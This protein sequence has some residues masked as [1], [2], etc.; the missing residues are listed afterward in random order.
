MNNSS[1]LPDIKHQA[2]RRMMSQIRRDEG[3]YSKLLA[4]HNNNRLVQAQNT[5]N[6]ALRKF[7]ASNPN[8]NERNQMVSNYYN[9]KRN[10]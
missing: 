4:N 5:I 7:R 8:K 6:D 9:N 3:E 10:M 1:A 2:K